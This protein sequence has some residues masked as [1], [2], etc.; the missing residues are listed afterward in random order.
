MKY[1]SNLF[2]FVVF[3][4]MHGRTFLQMHHSETILVKC[5]KFDEFVVITLLIRTHI[6]YVLQ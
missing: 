3:L 1:K 5:H 2:L 6:K 4:A